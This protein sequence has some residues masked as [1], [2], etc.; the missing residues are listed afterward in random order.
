MKEFAGCSKKAFVFLPL[1]AGSFL[2]HGGEVL[3]IP[4]SRTI[5][6]LSEIA[7]HDAVEVAEGAVLT[8]DLAADEELVKPISGAGSLIKAGAG[9]LTISV[10][11]TFTGTF[12]I[13]GGHVH[14]KN[15][16]AFGSADGATI[17]KTAETGITFFGIETSEP[18]EYDANNNSHAYAFRMAAGTT[19][20]FNGDVKHKSALHFDVEAGAKCIFNGAY[21]CNGVNISTFG[22]DSEVV[23][24]GKYTGSLWNSNQCKGKLV[25]NTQVWNQDL[26]YT[27]NLIVGGIELA[28]YNADLLLG[29]SFYNNPNLDLNGYDQ[30]VT[31][32]SRVN[33]N[34]HL[35]NDTYSYV[36]SAS[37]AYL[38]VSDPHENTL[39]RMLFKDKAGL[40]WEGTGSTTLTNVM[41]SAGNLAVK[42]G[43][44]RFADRAVS[45][46][47]Q[48][49]E[50]DVSG[51][52]RLVLADARQL[53][54]PSK[55]SLADTGVLRIPAGSTFNVYDLCL[56]GAKK[57]AGEY[58]VGDLNGHLEGE[59]AKIRVIGT[60]FLTVSENEVWNDAAIAAF[61]A[62]GRGGVE[63][64][65]GVT[66]S[67]SNNADVGF[68]FPIVGA[69]SLVKDGSGDLHLYSP[70]FFEGSFKIIGT[71]TVFVHHDDALG[72]L[73]GST[74][75]YQYEVDCNGNAKTYINE[76]HPDWGEQY[77]PGASLVLS[78]VEIYEPIELY[79]QNG[80]DLAAAENTENIVNGKIVLN[81]KEVGI[82]A[83]AGGVLR[84]R[85]G[86][87][88]GTAFRPGTESENSRIII[89][90]TPLKNAWV[91]NAK[92]GQVK[93]FLSFAVQGVPN[94]SLGYT[95]HPLLGGCEWA[96]NGSELHWS[97]GGQHMKMDLGGYNQRV[98]SIAS[99]ANM[100]GYITSSG[101][102]AAFL[103]V[104]QAAEQVCHTPFLGNAGFRLDVNANVTM[105]VQ[106]SS[107]GALEV[108][109]G[110]LTLAPGGEW[111]NC[112][113]V[114]IAGDGVFAVGAAGAV[115][116]KATISVSDAG[117]IDIPAGVNLVVESFFVNGVKLPSGLYSDA[118]GSAKAH[119]KSGGGTLVVSGTGLKIFMR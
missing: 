68:E 113:S 25:Y 108:L 48:V 36:T 16:G 117:L 33:A 10:A 89:E 3:T 35:P 52:G 81:G 82:L 107:E 2:S 23:F 44:V 67:V 106:S 15:N 62:S 109:D 12:E 26:G 111:P 97:T 69:G 104:S 99:A 88:G 78:G 71:G 115:S 75:L 50:I 85:G 45:S 57:A 114:K 22:A 1:L 53:G 102:N 13:A 40:C 92:A 43:T 74:M 90:N 17:V 56:D 94:H 101:D 87:E 41:T 32:I 118:K 70:N 116:R 28:F 39:T 61:I 19:T 60:G 6:S 11:N 9:T 83:K 64:P 54:T 37:S 66:L 95:F 79:G 63:I 100:N 24:N 96:F 4:Q 18:F 65:A 91:W 34:T 112:T 55:L 31:S 110:N 58:T 5:T 73:S 103:H 84:I 80:G 119:F 27:G 21:H 72:S 7:W 86:I 47:E 77:L 30:H 49:G 93:G 42:A 76:L 38:R 98:K 105:N 8:L 51:T 14:A 59:G 20:V 46:W 29:A